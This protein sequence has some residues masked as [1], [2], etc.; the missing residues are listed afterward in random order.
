MA[1]EYQGKVSYF[2]IHLKIKLM[3]NHFIFFLREENDINTPK[4]L[5]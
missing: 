5:F 1:L 4:L 3:K 2:M